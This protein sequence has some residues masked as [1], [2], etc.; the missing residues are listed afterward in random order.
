MAMASLQQGKGKEG[1]VELEIESCQKQINLLAG[2]LIV[3]LDEIV[4]VHMSVDFKCR[5]CSCEVPSNVEVLLLR[6]CSRLGT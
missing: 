4:Q 3:Q 1:I 5:Q 2:E 6:T